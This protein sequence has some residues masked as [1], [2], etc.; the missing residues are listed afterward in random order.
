MR[1]SPSRHVLAGKWKQLSG[2]VVQ[3]WG[4]LTGNNMRRL[5]GRFQVLAGVFEER[6]GHARARS[7]REAGR[8]MH[9]FRPR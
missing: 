6:Y 9:R 5:H 3:W 8:F 2:R 4:R 1:T 7:D